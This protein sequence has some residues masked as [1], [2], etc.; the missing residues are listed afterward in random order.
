MK[1]AI[2]V[3]ALISLLILAGCAVIDEAKQRAEEETQ[4][5][6][7]VEKQKKCDEFCTKWGDFESCHNICQSRY[8]S[9]VS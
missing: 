1:K 7:C 8:E 2:I 4:K 9:C 6:I 3:V 5:I